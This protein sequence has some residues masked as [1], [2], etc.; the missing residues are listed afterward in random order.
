MVNIAFTLSLAA[1]A[2][3]WWPTNRERA[4]RRRS[5]VRHA[6]FGGRVKLGRGRKEGLRWSRGQEARF[7]RMCALEAEQSLCLC[8]F[9][10]DEFLLAP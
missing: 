7:V 3:F 4:C 8:A 1:S 9:V 5:E 10:A 2:A 6:D